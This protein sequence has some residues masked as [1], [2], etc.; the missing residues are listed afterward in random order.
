MASDYQAIWIEHVTPEIDSGRYP[1]KREAGDLL[2]VSA[3]IF[4]DGHDKLACFLLHRKKGA[5]KW[6]R[7]RMEPMQHDRWQASITLDVIGRHEYTVYAYLDFFASWQD[8]VRKKHKADVSLESELLEGQRILQEARDRAPK[9]KASEFD[10][11]IEKLS[12]KPE[13]EAIFHALNP[14]MAHLVDQS[15]DESVSGTYD[16][17]LQA[18][19]EPVQARYAAW[20]EF[21]P[22]SQGTR[23][24][25]SAT[26][27]E[28]EKR[29]P[30]IKAM[31]FDV[32]YLPPIHPIGETNRKGANNSLHPKPDEPGCPYAIGNKHG[33][34]KAVHPDL[35]TLK[36]FDHFVAACNEAGISVALDFAVN[37]SPDHPYVKDHP[38]WFSKRPDGTIKYSENPPKKYEDIYGLDFH[39]K[40]NRKGLWEELKSVIEFWIDHGVT[41]FRVDNPHTKP[42]AFWEWMIASI[43]E[44]HPETIFLAEAFTRPSMMKVLGKI[45]FSQSYTYFTWRNFK[46]EITEYFTELTQGEMQDYYRGNLFANTPDILPT[47][48]QEG[49]RPAFKIRLALAATLSSVYGIYS[50]YE[51]CENRALPGKEEYLDSEK[52][53]IT[54]WDWNREGNIKDFVTRVNAIRRENPALHEYN[55][56]EFYEADNENIL[57]Y[58]KRTPDN[59]NIILVVVNL[60]PFEKQHSF[61]HLPLDQFGIPDDEI[62]QVHDLVTDQRF[63]WQGRRNYVEIDPTEESAHIFC[64]RRWLKRENDFDYFSM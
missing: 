44:K 12:A 25:R 2:Q 58:G 16:R 46:Q 59:S 63:L 43:Q 53:E 10:A 33:G 31:G 49:G 22:R 50:G 41:T 38:E 23:T 45:G 20:Y 61:I 6:Q 15:P 42:I 28:C 1:V 7:I 52:Y 54:V 60:N 3:D 40:E 5:R 56:L 29:I 47:F 14:A 27:K 13:S 19:V 51:L 11:L 24:D 9:G 39:C 32:I 8:E 48:L 18:I 62:Y 21:F 37:C 4:K 34:H 35:G 55:N 26:F 64:V 57:F 17:V 36:D 30:D